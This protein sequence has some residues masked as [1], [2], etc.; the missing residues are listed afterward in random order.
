[1]DDQKCTKKL[2]RF[3]MD[4]YDR[5]VLGKPSQCFRKFSLNKKDHSRPG[6][7]FR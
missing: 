2:A 3:V 5:N 1:M 7:P 6:I 4:Y